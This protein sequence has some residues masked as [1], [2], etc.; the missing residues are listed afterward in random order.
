MKNRVNHA[1]YKPGEQPNTSTIAEEEKARIRDRLVPLLARSEPLVRQQLIPV[2]QRVLQC[3]F[4]SRWPRYIDFTMELLNTNDPGS[5]LAGLQCLL[6]LC[7]AF[8]YRS[9]DSDDRQHFD[10][11]VE[12]SFPRL[13]TICNELVNQE[14][15]EAGEMLHLALKAY[16]HASWVGIDPLRFFLISFPCTSCTTFAT[17]GLINSLAGTLPALARGTG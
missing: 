2:L 1:W 6:A 15:D 14:S 9:G 10:K 4:P 13:L 11:I 7:R 5:V 17:M 8:R 3:D 16:K 12:A